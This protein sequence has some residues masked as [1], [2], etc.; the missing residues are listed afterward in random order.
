MRST[1]YRMFPTAVAMS[2]PGEVMTA[3][4]VIKYTNWQT[5]WK[6]LL[7]ESPNEI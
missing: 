5:L 6:S 3:L 1:N 4:P 7:E 2:P